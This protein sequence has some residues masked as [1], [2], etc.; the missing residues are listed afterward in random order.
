MIAMN[1]GRLVLGVGLMVLA[2]TIYIVSTSSGVEFY[3]EDNNENLVTTTSQLTD[4]HTIKV[5]GVVDVHIK[6]SDS[7]NVRYV[8][9]NKQFKNKSTFED[10]ELKMNF[11]S[12][13]RG[14]KLF[15]TSNY[16]V[17]AYV[18]VKRLSHIQMNGVGT[19]KTEGLLETDQIKVVNKGTGSMKLQL[20][21]IK[22]KG[23][24]AGVGSL[25]LSG[26][27]DTASLSNK[28]VGSL[29]AEKLI[30][31]V[32]DGKNDG[33]GS[34]EVYAEKEIKLRN[35]GVGSLHYSGSAQVISSR[36]EGIGSISK[37]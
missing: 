34:M 24:N 20:D 1:K 22:I 35:S 27:A 11:P 21:A 33:I 25:R 36:S 8:F 16:K 29:D 13:K 2:L 14:F 7:E 30:V 10:G 4:I 6:M 9:N 31:Q 5:N 26:S 32:L 18:S 3:N 17:Q 28:G 19:V 37:R 15:G 12:N 23:Y